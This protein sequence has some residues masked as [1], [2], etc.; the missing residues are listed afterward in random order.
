M[1][2]IKD[3]INGRG[4]QTDRV[5]ARDILCYWTVVELGILMVDLERK[6]DITPAVV[7]YAVQREEKIAMERG[8][9]LET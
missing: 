3:H 9:Q 8:C 5:R 2:D 7:S 1:A 4:G 6:F